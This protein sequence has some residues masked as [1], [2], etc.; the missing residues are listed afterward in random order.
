M[1]LKFIKIHKGNMNQL[2]YITENNLILKKIE[3]KIALVIVKATFIYFLDKFTQV[4]STIMFFN[5]EFNLQ[6]PNYYKDLKNEE[7]NN[8]LEI[9]YR[10]LK[11]QNII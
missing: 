5:Y 11:A 2:G 3:F 8:H 7:A 6:K 9:N 1:R 10:Y 4:T